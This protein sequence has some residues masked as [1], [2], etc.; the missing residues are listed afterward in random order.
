[1]IDRRL[2]LA[3]AVAVW[4]PARVTGGCIHIGQ[5]RHLDEEEFDEHIAKSDHLITFVE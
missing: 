4:L 1:M 2:L 3:A 5:T